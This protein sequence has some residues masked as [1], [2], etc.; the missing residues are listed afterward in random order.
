MSKCVHCCLGYIITFMYYLVCCQ[1]DCTG[2]ARK[3]IFTYAIYTIL[4]LCRFK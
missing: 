1:T 4:Q 3:I 2:D